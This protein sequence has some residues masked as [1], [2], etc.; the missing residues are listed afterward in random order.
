MALGRNTSLSY[1][2]SGVA[3]GHEVYIYNFTGD[4]PK[5]R[6]DEI[7]A[8]HLTADKALCENLLKNYQQRNGEIMTQVAA[9]NLEKLIALPVQRVAEFLPQEMQLKSLKLNEVEF[10]VQ[11]LE[12]MKAPF[13]P[14]GQQDVNQV[15]A[16]LKNLF[17]QY[18]FNCPIGLGDKEIPQEINR[19]LNAK[20][21]TPTAEFELNDDALANAMKSMMVECRNLYSSSDAKL[22][23]KP[24]NSAQSLGVFA[25]EFTED[26]L[27]FVALKKQ[28][29]SEINA[30]QNHQ[31]KNNLSD[32]EL[33]KII[34]V[35]CYVQNVK[36][37]EMLN[38]VAPEQIL[39]TARNLYNDKILVQPFLQGVAVG[40]IR[41]NILKNSHGDFYIA[42]QTFRKSL[43]HE[44]KNFTTGY[45]SGGATAQPVTILQP[46]E[47]S[48]LF[49]KSEMILKILNGELRQKYHNVIEL[50]ADFI[51]VGDGKNI[52][53]GEINHHCQ[54]LIPLSEALVHAIDKNA[55]YKG[56]L[57]LTSQA[58]TN[59][60]S[61][62]NIKLA[63]HA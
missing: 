55:I 20:I 10:L 61:H 22:V 42:G 1:I 62:Q 28:K 47:I 2:L 6:D 40:D 3:L 29:I 4:L 34:E 58:I 32:V 53:L 17:P 63:C 49:S 19:I 48:N 41:V 12:P 25:V 16:Q 36:S 45:S 33:K 37:D 24:K 50:G 11:R 30:S 21:A 31:I 39:K 52:F 44:D 23:F 13:P 38:N 15:L 60:I 7:S 8:L 9:K 27:D 35:L 57:E 14:A 18:V 54:A 26:G 59:W 56:G 51:L 46:E 43:R 5:N